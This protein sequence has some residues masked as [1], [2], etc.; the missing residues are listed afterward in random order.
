[1][2]DIIDWANMLQRF[3]NESHALIIKAVDNGE[4]ITVTMD[5][6]AF[7][8]CYNRYWFENYIADWFYEQFQCEDYDVEVRFEDDICFVTPK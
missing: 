3:L 7:L 8:Q 6:S 5:Y 2:E 4:D 1:M